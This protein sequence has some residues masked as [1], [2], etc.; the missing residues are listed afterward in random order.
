MR[1]PSAG[2]SGGVMARRLEYGDAQYLPWNET[3][4]KVVGFLWHH[5]KEWKEVNDYLWSKI[6]DQL[7]IQFDHMVHADIGHALKG[8]LTTAED[9]EKAQVTV[10]RV[11]KTSAG[12]RDGKNTPSTTS[13]DSFDEILHWIQGVELAEA[14]DARD[15]E[16]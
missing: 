15:A 4:R 1:S 9:I 10:G 14:T 8:I 3:V 16:V 6:M 12:T 13:T 11:G 2:P 5:N 7:P